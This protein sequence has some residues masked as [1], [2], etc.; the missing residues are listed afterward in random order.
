[1]PSQG[2]IRA[3]CFLR[4]GSAIE[5]TVYITQKEIGSPVEV[6]GK[7]A[8]LE[9]GKHAIHVHE[10]GDISNSGLNA[11]GLF[12]PDGK[13]I[14][15][16]DGKTRYVGELGDVTAGEDGSAQVS[17][18]ATNLNLIGPQSIIGRSIIVHE[19]EHDVSAGRYEVTAA[20]QSGRIAY[21]VVG[22][23]K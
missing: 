8:G 6:T 2:C 1:M 19:K 21:G 4:G 18:S 16:D 9:P 5:G 23:C 15:T 12:N 3:V 14:T 20:N 13:Y 11:G 7:I 22:I 10:Y 17:F